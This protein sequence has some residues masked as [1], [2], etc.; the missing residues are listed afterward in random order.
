[1]QSQT[2]DLGGLASNLTA[3]A[4]SDGADALAQIGTEGLKFASFIGSGAHQS[5]GEMVID[6]AGTT[7][8]Q[9]LTNHFRDA[10]AK[11]TA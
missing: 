10:I 3:L 11:V 6:S 9:D 2:G 4:G 5:Y 1:Q 8:L 7:A